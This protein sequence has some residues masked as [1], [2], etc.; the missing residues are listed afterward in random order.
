[1]LCG[2]PCVATD[3]GDVGKIVGDKGMVITTENPLDFAKAT[4]DLIEEKNFSSPAMKKAIR[5]RITQKF[6]IEEIAKK[7]LLEYQRAAGQL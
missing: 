4:S 1:M 3:V 6:A 2:I 7:F 5:Q